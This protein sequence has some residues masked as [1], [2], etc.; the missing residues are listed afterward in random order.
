MLTRYLLYLITC[1]CD[2]I[3][4][5]S[6]THTYTYTHIIPLDSRERQSFTPHNASFSSHNAP[7]SRTSV[8]RTKHRQRKHVSRLIPTLKISDGNCNANARLSFDATC[9]HRADI[10]SASSAR[11]FHLRNRAETRTRPH[12]VKLGSALKADL[13]SCPLSKTIHC[14]WS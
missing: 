7:A 1:S 4:K 5:V 9:C 2:L 6:H 3:T 11:R 8:K 13:F 10:E 12:D 14:V